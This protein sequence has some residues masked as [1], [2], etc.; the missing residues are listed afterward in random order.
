MTM[1]ARVNFDNIMRVVSKRYGVAESDLICSPKTENGRKAQAM[2]VYVSYHLFDLTTFA[3]MSAYQISQVLDVKERMREINESIRDNPAAKREFV[4]LVME[5][6]EDAE[7]ELE[8]LTGANPAEAA[9]QKRVQEL[10][11]QLDEMAGS[12]GED[13]GFNQE[14]FDAIL[15][16]LE[17]LEPLP[18]VTE[19][20]TEESL[21]KFWRKVDRRERIDYRLFYDFVIAE[22]EELEDRG[23]ERDYKLCKALAACYELQDYL[24][25]RLAKV[26]LRENKE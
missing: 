2:A 19:A 11:E 3:I 4:A 18:P 6:R 12:A 8:A 16:E 1:D 10:G 21:R 5:I 26:A 20:D 25:N 7:L 23:V 17:E 13:G 15:S 24:A 9:R 22:E 14:R